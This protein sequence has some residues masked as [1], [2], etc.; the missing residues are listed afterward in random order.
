MARDPYLWAKEKI[1]FLL[2]KTDTIKNDGLKKSPGNIWSIK[3]LLALDYYVGGSHILFKKNFAN[4]YYVDTHCGSGLIGFE[5]EKLQLERFPGSPLIAA[6]RANNQPFTDYH[7][8]DID[9]ESI[10][11]LS[12]RLQKMKL[13][14]GNRVYFPMTRSFEATADYV[15]RYKKW[16]NA[17]LI[18]IDP[19]GFTEL[20]WAV[21]K[22]FLEIKTAD[23]FLTFMTSFIALNRTNAHQGTEYEKTFD[24]V[25]GVPDWRKE[26]GVDALLE[27]YLNQIRK[28]RNYVYTIP[29]YRAGENRLYDIIVATNSR[30]AGSIIDYTKKIMEI[31]T[32]ELIEAALKVTTKKDH[33]LDEWF[34][35]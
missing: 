9:G 10:N 4:W 35:D 17:F 3:K 20:K 7:F 1:S 6:L 29:V 33:D 18:F 28:F 8:S 5:K 22:K 26:I 25:Y 2:E 31:L 12:Q 21:M 11:Y 13:Q 14:V 15:T 24:E 23:I 19:I 30:G 34:D 27:V 16:G 32:T